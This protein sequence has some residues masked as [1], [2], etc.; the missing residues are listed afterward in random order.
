[1]CTDEVANVIRIWNCNSS[2]SIR[3]TIMDFKKLPLDEAVVASLAEAKRP[4]YIYE[5]LRFLER[6]LDQ[7]SRRGEI[8][9]NID[10]F[11]NLPQK[12]IDKKDVACH[13]SQI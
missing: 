8:R 13:F 3:W 4:V 11:E 6:A 12:Y 5:W 7:P 10:A 9:E 2:T 1:M